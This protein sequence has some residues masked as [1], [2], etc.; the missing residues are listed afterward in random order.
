MMIY[1]LMYA[2][3]NLINNTNPGFKS[4]RSV[5][6]EDLKQGGHR[7]IYK[8]FLLHYLHYNALVPLGIMFNTYVAKR[9]PDSTYARIAAGTT[10]IAVETVKY[11]VLTVWKR[12]LMSANNPKPY[13]TSLECVADMIEEG[14]MRSFFRGYSVYLAYIALISAGMISEFGT[15]SP[16]QKNSQLSQE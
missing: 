11:A 10:F 14:G 13:R 16:P 3:I 5:I 4:Y 1:P 9:T 8:G 7:K 15:G 6:M 2:E 12:L